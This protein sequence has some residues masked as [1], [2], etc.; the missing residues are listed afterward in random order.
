MKLRIIWA[1][2]IV[3]LILTNIGFLIF[4]LVNAKGLEDIGM[5]GFFVMI[6]FLF[7]GV[8]GFGLYRYLSWIKNKKI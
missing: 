2:P 1:I 7:T 8:I 3:F 5:L 4:M 6:W